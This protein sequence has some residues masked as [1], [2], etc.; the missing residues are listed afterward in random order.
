MPEHETFSP[1]W[2]VTRLEKKLQARRRELQRYQDYY[3]GK[4]PLVFASAKFRKA[5]G[6]LFSEFAD[7]WCEIVVDAV[8]E[9]LNVEGF[10]FPQSDDAQ[11]ESD[12]DAWR[13]WQANQL[14][15]ESQMAHTTALVKCESS[16]IIDPWRSPRGSDAPLITIEDPLEVIV[17]HEPGNRRN[18]AAA[19]KIWRDEWESRMLATL[20]LP[21]AIYKFRSATRIEYTKSASATTRWAKREVPG[22]AWPLPNPLGAL[23]VVPLR[24]RPTL[25]GAG[26]SEIAKVLPIQDGINKLV[27]DM[28]VASEY[29]AFKQRWVTGMEI[30]TDPETGK[31]IEPFETAVNRLW[32][33]EN[34]EA[35]FGEF[36]AS[37]LS[38]FTNAIQ[39]LVGHV[40]SQ[41]RTPP[42]YL[43]PAADRLSGESIKAA[44]T[45]LVA[46]TRRKF[47]HFGEG[48]EEVLR[49]AFMVLDDPRADV[50][51]SETIWADPESRS[52]AEHVDAVA[53]KKALDVPTAQ[54][55]EDLGY[56]PTQIENF[57]TMRARA[58]LL[59]QGSQLEALVAP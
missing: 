6:G 31:Q 47:R 45:G 8:E 58:A 15:A 33:E 42:H 14:D 50:L 49:V 32:M 4:H 28:F 52:E 12:T 20:Y 46:K 25:A 13:I 24:N 27:A 40:A 55:W 10:R 18:R 1:L 56:S 35:R 9:R 30:P 3:D 57:E 51:N 29:A 38:N 17:E 11:A 44:E 54:L 48:W 23:L 36:T 16:A 53:K 5:F 21:D 59:D 26:R 19:L 2:W 39:M 22:E 37:D 41:T 43:N 34:P 7:N